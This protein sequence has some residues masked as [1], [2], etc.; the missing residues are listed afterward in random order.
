MVICILLLEDGRTRV[1]VDGVSF[2]M[3]A[4]ERRYTQVRDGTSSGKRVPRNLMIQGVPFLRTKLGN[5][6][7]KSAIV[8]L[9]SRKQ[10]QQSRR[11]CLVYN[12]TGIY[13]CLPKYD[14]GVF[15]GQCKHAA[16]PYVHDPK[17]VLVCPNWLRHRC[18]FKT[19]FPDELVR[20]KPDCR[21][22]LPKRMP[23]RPQD[24]CYFSHTMRESKVPL[25]S[26]F[27]RGMCDKEECPYVHVKMNS[28][29]PVCPEFANGWYCKATITG[30][31]CLKRHVYEC[32][33]WVQS[34]GICMRLEE[35][36][37]CALAHPK[38]YARG[39]RVWPSRWDRECDFVDDGIDPDQ[40]HD[41]EEG[42]FIPLSFE[43]DEDDDELEDEE[44]SEEEED[45]DAQ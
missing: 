32:P 28:T 41:I 6:V 30:G 2:I 23:V 5:L 8:K 45:P 35:G 24:Q 44:Y 15:Q 31:H 1:T 14:T 33:E 18:K 26:F 4:D 9:P 22:V 29:A 36:K 10:L 37:K 20:V 42:N 27:A 40:S 25:C 11:D 12:R 21:F 19:S 34:N 13:V 38:R 17:R 16:C 39:N 7:Q 43:E 3:S